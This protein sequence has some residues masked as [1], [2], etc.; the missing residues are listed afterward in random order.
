MNITFSMG[1]GGIEYGFEILKLKIQF[2]GH[3]FTHVSGSNGPI[4]SKKNRIHP[5]VDS[6][7]PCEFYENW[8]KTAT[9]IVIVIIITS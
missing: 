7:Q 3:I 4:V 8:F 6:H 2:W 9:H 1:N 5:C